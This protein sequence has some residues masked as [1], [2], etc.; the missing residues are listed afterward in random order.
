[1]WRLKSLWRRFPEAREWDFWL[2]RREQT[3]IRR[4]RR[5]IK[6]TRQGRWERRLKSL[7]KRLSKLA[8]HNRDRHEAQPHQPGQQE[9]PVARRGEQRPAAGAGRPGG[10]I[11]HVTPSAGRTRVGAPDGPPGSGRFDTAA[12]RPLARMGYMD[13]SVVTPETTFA[14]N[15]PKMAEDGRSVVV[16]TGA[17]DGAY[18]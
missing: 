14:L 9:D 17:W 1:M 4:L 3:I 7:E 11:R 8:R 6:A 5:K 18:R 15:R 16:D 12:V 10:P 2:R 13:Y